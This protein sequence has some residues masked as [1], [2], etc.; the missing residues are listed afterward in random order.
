MTKFPLSKLWDAAKV[1]LRWKFT[2]IDHQTREE[3]R[4][5]IDEKNTLVATKE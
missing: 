2:A 3:E 4:L 1:M 5:K